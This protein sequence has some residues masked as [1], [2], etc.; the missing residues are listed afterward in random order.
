MKTPHGE[1]MTPAFVPVATNAAVKALR[2][3]EIA[4]TKTQILIANTYHLHLAPG[5]KIVKES[6]G[7]HSFMNWPKPMMTDSGGF[8]YLVWDSGGIWEWEK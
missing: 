8:R 7:L 5:E 3:D 4:Q 1:V 6:G 2:S